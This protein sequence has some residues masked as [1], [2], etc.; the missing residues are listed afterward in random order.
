VSGL[1]GAVSLGVVDGEVVID[2]DYDEDSRA[3]T[4]MNIV[5]AEKGGLIEVQGTAEGRP[6]TRE[7]LDRML[8]LASAGIDQLCKLQRKSLEA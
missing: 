7:Q 8:D 4:D 5:M 1:V 6:F 3:E 2:L